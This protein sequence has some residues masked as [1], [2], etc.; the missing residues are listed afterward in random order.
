MITMFRP[1]DVDDKRAVTVMTMTMWLIVVTTI[2][3][4]MNTCYYR[5]WILRRRRNRKTTDQRELEEATTSYAECAAVDNLEYSLT[6]TFYI[7]Q[8]IRRPVFS[9]RL[10]IIVLFL[11]P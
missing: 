3:W 8:L 1:D 6:Q 11:H 9:T 2:E 4:T 7:S 5:Q 10:A